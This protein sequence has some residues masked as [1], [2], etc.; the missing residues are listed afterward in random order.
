MPGNS[1]GRCKRGLGATVADL[2]TGIRAGQKLAMPGVPCRGDVFHALNEVIPVV[3]YLENRAYDA[4]AGHDKLQHK[5]T[6]VQTQ[7]RRDQ[8]GQLPAL[9]RKTFLAAQAETKAI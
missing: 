2:G 7:A 4:V 6:K 8:V 3:S 1:I 9:S 5:K